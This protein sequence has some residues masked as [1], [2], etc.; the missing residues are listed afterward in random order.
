MKKEAIP[1][2]PFCRS[3]MKTSALSSQSVPLLTS[4]D[5][6][7]RDRQ[8][9]N[10][11]HDTLTALLPSSGLL[12]SSADLPFSVHWRDSNSKSDTHTSDQSFS[13]RRHKSKQHSHLPSDHLFFSSG[14]HDSFDAR[15][16]AMEGGG[17][18]EEEDL[19][20]RQDWGEGEVGENVHSIV[21][22]L[23]K[24]TVSSA[25][26][27]GGS[28][29]RPGDGEGG[30]RRRGHHDP[31][32]TMDMRHKQVTSSEFNVLQTFTLENIY[33]YCCVDVSMVRLSCGISGA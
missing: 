29:E 28:R 10:L 3:G 25:G 6:D 27:G 22:A 1:I 14:R 20:S 30:K 16:H 11:R 8:D 7:T 4:H 2:L 12:S 33:T 26:E 19:L 17:E 21:Q 5:F 13:T 24:K 9:S 32:V 31:T 15:H 23:M 18:G